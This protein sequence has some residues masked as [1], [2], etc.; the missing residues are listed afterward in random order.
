MTTDVQN[1]NYKGKTYIVLC[2]AKMKNTWF[3]ADDY[4]KFQLYKQSLIDDVGK[5]FKHLAKNGYL[6]QEGELSKA[7]YKITEKGSRALGL[8]G[9]HRVKAEQHA[10]S[11]NIKN[12]SSIAAARN[13]RWEKEKQTAGGAQ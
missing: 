13:R 10:L 1:I 11:E 12:N 3:S 2:Y 9:A 7:R 5:S 8:V 4:R 6:L